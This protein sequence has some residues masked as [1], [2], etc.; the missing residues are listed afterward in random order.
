MTLREDVQVKSEVWSARS[1]K[2][3]MAGDVTTR[4]RRFHTSTYT[5]TPP[6]QK[7]YEAVNCVLAR[8]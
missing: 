2:R 8:R 4:S 7:M 5:S 1:V 6:H 3:A